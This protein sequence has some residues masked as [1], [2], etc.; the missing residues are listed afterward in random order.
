MTLGEKSRECGERETLAMMGPTGYSLVGAALPQAGWSTDA[1]VLSA[2]CLVL[3]APV[4]ARWSR[5]SFS[6]S[7]RNRC[8]TL[9][10][11]EGS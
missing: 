4:S 8:S 10:T 6:P 1:T 7:A 2:P 5:S 11:A 9:S 3:K